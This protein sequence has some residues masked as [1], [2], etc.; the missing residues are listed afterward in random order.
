M[1][2]WRQNKVRKSPSIGLE[3]FDVLSTDPFQGEEPL[4]LDSDFLVSEPA[5]QT[6]VRSPS[7]S[8]HRNARSIAIYSGIAIALALLGFTISKVRPWSYLSSQELVYA[9]FEVRAVDQAGRPIAG[10]LVKNAGKKVGTTDS[11]G[12]WRR[13]MRVPLGATVPVTLAKSIN[14]EILYATKNFAVPP[15]KPEKSDLDLRASVQLIATSGAHK[16]ISSQAVVAVDVNRARADAVTPV[17]TS[18]AQAGGDDTLVATN[19][20]HTAENA[21]EA[22]AELPTTAETHV[23]PSW[24]AFQSSHQSVWF[25][26]MGSTASPLSKDVLPALV[27]R[28]KELGLKVDPKAEWRVRLTSLTDRPAVMGSDGGGLILI[29][30]FDKGQATAREFLRNYQ[31]D[32]RL[33]A[34]GILFVLSHE[35][36]KNVAVGRVGD[37]WVA[38]LPKSSAELWTLSAGMSLAGPRSSVW[39]A[40]SEKYSNETWSGYFLQ[41]PKTSEGPCDG[42]KNGCEISLRTFAEVPPVPKWTKIRAKTQVNLKDPV[43]IFVSGYEARA[44]SDNVIEYWGEDR[45]RVNVTVVNAGRVVHRAQIVNDRKSLPLIAVRAGAVSRR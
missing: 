26:A 44:V 37:R 6:S 8:F 35:V 31:S 9:Y 11:F 14:G 4:D 40:G 28:S 42:A 16:S 17:A 10:A 21:K 3:S 2:I 22:S 20:D 13:Y 15:T 19:S 27:S 5:S 33:T 34:R 45:A 30:S 36:Q 43:K 18:S 12:E 41:V 32:S 29:S 39:L 25:E 23:A 7:R 38:A 1:T 24:P